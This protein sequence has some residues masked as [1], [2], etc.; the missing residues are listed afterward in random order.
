MLYEVITLD[1][2]NGDVCRLDANGADLVGRVP[3]GRLAL[4]EHGL[5][6]VPEAVLAE[7]RE[8]GR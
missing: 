4:R 3:T 7:M 8:H 5:E 1:A 6:P 2:R